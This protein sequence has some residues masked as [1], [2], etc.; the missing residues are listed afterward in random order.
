MIEYTPEGKSDRFPPS[1]HLLRI[2]LQFLARNKRLEPHLLR[3]PA[4]VSR[5][6]DVAAR[7][8]ARTKC[9]L[10]SSVQVRSR[11]FSESDIPGQP[12]QHHRPSFRVTSWKTLILLGNVSEC[13]CRDFRESI[14]GSSV[15]GPKT[16]LPATR[17]GKL[18][19]EAIGSHKLGDCRLRQWAPVSGT[20]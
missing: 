6:M 18:K 9:S 8:I 2:K 11:G 4:P 12:L 17:R 7:A 20:V 1:A 5:P 13:P 19:T 10:G 15:R 16:Q 14:S 3:T